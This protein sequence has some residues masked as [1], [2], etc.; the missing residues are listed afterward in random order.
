MRPATNWP[1]STSSLSNLSVMSSSSPDIYHPH[2][3]LDLLADQIDLQQS[4]CQRGS[5]DFDAIGQN[6]AAQKLSRRDA[7]VKER[8]VVCYSLA[9]ADH[10]LV[11]FLGDAKLFFRKAR[12]RQGD[13][14]AAILQLLDIVGRVG[15]TRRTG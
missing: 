14:D 12:H 9:S 8:F 11:I 2:S 3:K 6:E 10:Q 1:F 5:G 4:I 7:P 15:V 13:A